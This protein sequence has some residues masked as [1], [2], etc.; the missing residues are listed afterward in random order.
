MH[1]VLVFMIFLCDVS[2]EMKRNVGQKQTPYYGII[3]QTSSVSYANNTWSVYG[4]GNMESI[5]VYHNWS[6]LKKSLL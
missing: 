1:H 6:E 5:N 3:A 4:N 2:H